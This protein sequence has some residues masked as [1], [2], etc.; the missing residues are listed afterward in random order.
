MILTLVF[1]E[2]N[3]ANCFGVGIACGK[4]SVE[5]LLCGSTGNCSSLNGIMVL[6]LCSAELLLA[7]T[8]CVNMSSIHEF[9]QCV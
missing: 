6:K 1:K 4:L 7:N 5:L 9:T 2:I 3:F 8:H